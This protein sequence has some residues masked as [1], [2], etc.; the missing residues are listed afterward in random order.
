[1]KQSKYM[2]VFYF[3]FK[4]DRNPKK[5]MGSLVTPE[6]VL[7]AAHCVYGFLPEKVTVDIDDGDNKS[8]ENFI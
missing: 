7:T 6:F 5:C 2:I 8:N 1:M 3:K 4:T